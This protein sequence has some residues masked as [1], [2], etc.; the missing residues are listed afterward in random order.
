MQ[1]TSTS[2]GKLWMIAV[3]VTTIIAVASLCMILFKN[4]KKRRLKRKVLKETGRVNFQ[5]LRM[6]G[7]NPNAYSTN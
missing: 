5:Q 4:G 7:R 6:I 3:I 1:Q 2:N